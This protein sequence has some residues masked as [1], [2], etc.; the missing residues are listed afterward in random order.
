MRSS[1]VTDHME[2]SVNLILTKYY[3][4]VYIMDQN[5]AGSPQAPSWL[6]HSRY[7]LATVRP[8]V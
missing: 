3:C 7:S 1:H 2:F 8:S 5:F 6:R 4:I